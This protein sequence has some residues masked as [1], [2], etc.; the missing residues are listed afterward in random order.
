MT[1]RFVII[2]VILIGVNSACSTGG[3]VQFAPTAPALAG[4]L[5]QYTHPSG[6]FTLAVPRGWAVFEQNTA[7]LVSASFSPPDQPTAS[8]TIAVIEL[9]SE[10]DLA[11]MI[12]RYRL[13]RPDRDVY[14]LTECAPMNA[15]RWQC[16]GY[17][18]EPTRQSLNTFIERHGTRISV[19][20]AR[21]DLAPHFDAIEN[22]I[23]SFA[24]AAPVLTAVSVDTL[25]FV[26]TAPIAALHT[27]AWVASDGALFVTG[28]I[29]NYGAAPIS[30]VPV[31][32]V[33]LFADGRALMGAVDQAMGHGIE[34]GGFAPFSLRFGE[35]QAPAAMDYA[36]NVGRDGWSA[37]SAREFSRQDE[38]TTTFDSSTNAQG[39]LMITGE[40]ISSSTRALNDVRAVVTVFDAAGRVIGAATTE[41]TPNTLN[42]G[43]GGRYE[44]LFTALGG[45]PAN[46]SV[47]IQGLP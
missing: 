14:T 27:S 46:F 21:V 16:A 20:D 28:E 39:N 26:R 5:T 11:E 2:F 43:E 41:V 23:N 3:A 19:I 42:A 37:N 32:V 40:V 47:T 4:A 10:I 7:Q 25:A 35:G 30:D 29:A 33:I 15:E 9:G 13:I 44:L 17:R 12:E 36:V 6:A 8:V 24:I 34:S 22:M 38:F 45:I 18:T 31:E 1:R